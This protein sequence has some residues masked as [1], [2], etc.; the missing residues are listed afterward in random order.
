MAG[1]HC[2]Q[3]SKIQVIWEICTESSWS[4][5]VNKMCGLSAMVALWT[6]H[7]SLPSR[8]LHNFSVAGCDATIPK[9]QPPMPRTITRPMAGDASK[10]WGGNGLCSVGP[11]STSDDFCWETNSW[12]LVWRPRSADVLTFGDDWQMLVENTFMS[13]PVHNVYIYM[14]RYHW[15]VRFTIITSCTRLHCYTGRPLL[16]NVLTPLSSPRICHLIYH[17]KKS[18]FTSSKSNGFRWNPK[19]VPYFHAIS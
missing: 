15:Q 18:Q 5:A 1:Q 8:K 3:V 2:S 16:Q 4:M 6:E 10:R 9:M 19:G 12:S 7:L 17:P 11:F 13:Q 14:T